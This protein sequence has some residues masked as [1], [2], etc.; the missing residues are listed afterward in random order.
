MRGRG[1]AGAC[2]HA[3]FGGSLKRSRLLEVTEG[4]T[5]MPGLW[6]FPYFEIG[7]GPPILLMYIFVHHFV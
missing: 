7:S 2:P 3:T 5:H 1:H 4:Q 6:T